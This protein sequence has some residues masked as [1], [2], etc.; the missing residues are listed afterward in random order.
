M[1]KIHQI[2]IILH[3]NVLYGIQRTETL[4]FEIPPPPNQISTHQTFLDRNTFQ[5]IVSKF[6]FWL[7]MQT[8]SHVR[9]E[10]KCSSNEN[11]GDP[12]SVSKIILIR[13]AHASAPL[14]KPQII[15]KTELYFIKFGLKPFQL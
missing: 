2:P 5:V 14:D 9:A 4:D 13:F 3:T 1:I 11:T 7:T 8:S 6:G 10:R 15:C 12:V